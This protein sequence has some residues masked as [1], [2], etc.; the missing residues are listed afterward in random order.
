MRGYFGIGIENGK[1]EQNIGTLFRSALILGASFIFIIGR[2]Y[3]YQ[4]TDTTK[5][6]KHLPSYHY[7]DFEDFYNHLPYDCQL[8]GVELDNRATKLTS[9]QHPER[10]IYLL[11]AED[12]GL[13]KEALQ[14]CHKLVRIPGDISL[15]VS[16]AGSIVM[17]DR[18]AK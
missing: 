11:G 13:T 1:F 17:Y 2:R 4:C 10:C 18:L 15:N 9:F 16:V 14:S 5:S 7:L 6:T 12:H 8:I 3:K